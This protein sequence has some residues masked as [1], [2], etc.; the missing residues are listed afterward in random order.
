MTVF[1]LGA[2]RGGVMASLA[3]KVNR[4]EEGGPH[5]VNEVPVDD[6]TVAAVACAG[7]NL[8][9]RVPMSKNTKATRPPITWSPSKPGVRFL[10]SHRLY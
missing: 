8:L 7:V 2:H 6:T 1:P 5:D 10:T 3:H 4:G 9:I